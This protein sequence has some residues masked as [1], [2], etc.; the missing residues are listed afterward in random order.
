MSNPKRAVRLTLKLDADTKNDLARELENIASMIDRDELTVGVSGG[1]S[2]G[3]IY[4]LLHDPEQTHDKYF[5]ELRDY[6]GIKIH[7]TAPTNE[8]GNARPGGE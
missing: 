2:S 6:L 4:E 5:M 8:T 3:Y 7:E 1:F